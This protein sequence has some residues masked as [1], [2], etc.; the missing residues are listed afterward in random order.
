MLVATALAMVVMVIVGGTI[1]QN[2]RVNKSQQLSVA[3][4]S[5][6]RACLALITARLRSAG[7]DPTSAGIAVVQ[8]DSTPGDGID[9]IEVFADLD[10][11]GDTDGVDEQVRI[12]H[13]SAS[14]RIEWRRSAT[15][16]YDI[17]AMGITNDAD[18]NG[19]EEPMFVADSTTNP[20]YV[21]VRITAESVEPDP[22]TRMP[23][24]FSIASQIALRNV[25]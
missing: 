25:P 18:G 11:D 7:W 14:N 3:M 6:A 21:E 12:R 2:S 9:E 22:I 13:V 24:R 10:G 16:A 19:T 15:G 8:L 23:L 4:Q 17:L 1:V 20:R 5:D